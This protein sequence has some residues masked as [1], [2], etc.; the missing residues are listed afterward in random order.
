VIRSL[1]AAFIGN[2]IDRRDGRGGIKGALFGVATD[3]VVRRGGPFG[4]LLLGILGIWRLFFRR[5]TRTRYW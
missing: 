5:R 4:W 2:R 3:R 1:L